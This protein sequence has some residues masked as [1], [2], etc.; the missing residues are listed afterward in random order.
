MSPDQLFS[1]VNL[2]ALLGAWPRQ[3]RI[4]QI[5]AGVAVPAL[6]AT[7]YVAI[8][9]TKWADAAGGFSSLKDVAAL[10]GQSLAA[11]GR[12]DTLSGVRS[13]GRQPGSARRAPSRDPAPVGLALPALTFLFWTRGMAAVSGRVCRLSPGLYVTTRENTSS[14][15][16]EAR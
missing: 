3:H 2:S 15:R 10:F 11:A 6:L 5:V 1:V 4:P 7:V 9:A 14:S 16:R 13:V 12:L 8:V